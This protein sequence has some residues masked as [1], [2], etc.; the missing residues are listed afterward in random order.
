MDNFMLD[1][2]NVVISEDSS[3]SIFVKFVICD[4]D[5]NGNGVQLD[6]STISNWLPTLIN[7]PLL[8]KIEVSDDGDMDIVL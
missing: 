1:S 8:G 4:F 2:R 3:D 6:R 5:V 7:K